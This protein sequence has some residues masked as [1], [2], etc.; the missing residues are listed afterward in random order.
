M[1]LS[2]DDENLLKAGQKRQQSLAAALRRNLKVKTST[3]ALDQGSDG[4]VDDDEILKMSTRILKQLKKD[5]EEAKAA[6]RKHPI[7]KKKEMELAQKKFM[8]LENIGK[9]E[10][11]DTDSLNAN[12]RKGPMSQAPYYEGA[13]LDGMRDNWLGRYPRFAKK[14]MHV[15]KAD[16]IKEW[17]MEFPLEVL[18]KATTNVVELCTFYHDSQKPMSRVEKA[19]ET[20]NIN[21]AE[22]YTVLGGRC[23]M[24]TVWA[25]AV[26]AQIYEKS[27]RAPENQGEETLA[28]GTTKKSTKSTASSSSSS[29]SSGCG[30]KTKSVHPQTWRT[31]WNLLEN[32]ALKAT[33]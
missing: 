15:M 14:D 32:L 20:F 9:V 29:S 26:S 17:A 10:N 6:V 16:G 4:I 24:L 3:T 28:R 27:N 21:W 30:K 31:E 8:A 1:Q 19:L 2:K 18:E 23:F 11:M 33:S 7:K 13:P 5:E 25:I 22:R 12:S